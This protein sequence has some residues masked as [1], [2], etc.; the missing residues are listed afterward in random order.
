MTNQGTGRCDLIE[1]VDWVFSIAK[2]SGE[3]TKKFNHLYQFE[4]QLVNGTAE[5]CSA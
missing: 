4:A 2:G 5:K 3:I 1:V